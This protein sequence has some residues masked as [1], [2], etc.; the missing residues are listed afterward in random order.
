MSF[1]KIPPGLAHGKA[2]KKVVEKADTLVHAAPFPLIRILRK[3]L[4]F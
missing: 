2:L 3:D 1:A 4:G